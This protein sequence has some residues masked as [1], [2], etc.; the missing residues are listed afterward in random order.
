MQTHYSQ[1]LIKHGIAAML[2][3]LFAGFL[4]I[5]S[6]IGGMSLSP[7]PVLLEFD[8]P[9]TSKGWRIVHMGTLMNGMM[10]IL[11]GLAMRA[12]Y[13]SEAKAFRV[14]AGIAI[15]IWGNFLFYVFGMFA[16]NHGIT[17]EANVLG[18]ASMAGAIAFFPALLGAITSIYALFVLLFSEPAQEQK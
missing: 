13:L 1:L 10:A 11:I 12:F 14:F 16:P 6:L 9:G 15:A 18:E 2:V 17:L 5:F 8:L 4:L 7:V 3:G